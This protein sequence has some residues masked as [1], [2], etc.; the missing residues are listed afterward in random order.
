MSILSGSCFLVIILILVN[1]SH[2]HCMGIQTS[3][4][5]PEFHVFNYIPAITFTGN[6]IPIKD[7]L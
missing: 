4:V 5:Q 7:I 2:H 6:M 3:H 1:I